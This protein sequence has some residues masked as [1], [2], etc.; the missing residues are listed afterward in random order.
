[1]RPHRGDAGPGRGDGGGHA[2]EPA[3]RRGSAAARTSEPTRSSSSTPPSTARTGR[4]W[5]R[6]P[7]RSAGSTSKATPAH[8]Y[9]RYLT[10][11]DPELPTPFGGMNRA[12]KIIRYD[13]YTSWG[14]Q[15]NEHQY[16]KDGIYYDSIGGAWAGSHLQNFRRDQ[17]PYVDFP[18]T[19]DHK[20]GKVTIT[21]GF[22]AIEFLRWCTA[23]ARDDGRPTMGNAEPRLFPPVRRPL[24]G[25]GRRG[26]ELR[27]REPTSP[28]SRKC[29]R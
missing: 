17:M 22:S 23:Q 16:E 3:R 9:Y 14:R 24:P 7:R 4:S 26:R 19:F 10:N 12:Q 27:G 21:H 8:P 1:M 15:T 20:T 2:G 5:T 28:A 18:L 25:H 11:P 29:G 13:L 6:A